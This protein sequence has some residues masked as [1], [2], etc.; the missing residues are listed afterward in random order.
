MIEAYNEQLSV[1]GHS[2]A[3]TTTQ[4]FAIVRNANCPSWHRPPDLSNIMVDVAPAHLLFMDPSIAESLSITLSN[5]T[6]RKLY[7]IDPN[8][9][10]MTMTVSGASAKYS[11]SFNKNNGNDSKRTSKWTVKGPSTAFQQSLAIENGSASVSLLRLGARLDLEAL[12]DFLMNKP[13]KTSAH[14]LLLQYFEEIASKDAGILSPDKGT[15]LLEF[16]SM[17]SRPPR[18]TPTSDLARSDD[19]QKLISLLYDIL[20]KTQPEYQIVQQS[21]RILI[22]ALSKGRLRFANW[23]LEQAQANIKLSEIDYAELQ[24]RICAQG[25]FD[26]TDF[27]IEP[28]RTVMDSNAVKIVYTVG[29]KNHDGWWG[30]IRNDQ[31]REDTLTSENLALYRFER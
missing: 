17:Q 2:K 11:V 4:F 29:E 25:L 21:T 31:R 26:V 9:W 5:G 7:S 27:E 15:S 30:R 1:I 6:T 14:T 10:S 16:C 22:N 8:F 20:C 13:W 24:I 19:L 28:G 23:F 18:T 3:P 12:A